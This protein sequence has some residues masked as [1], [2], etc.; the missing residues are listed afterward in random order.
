M[1]LT[2]C[3]HDKAA[4]ILASKPNK[5]DI[6]FIS[7]PENKYA[8]EGSEKIAGLARESCEILFNDITFPIGHS[9]TVP[10]E[11][12][13]KKALDF[14]KGKKEL[15]IAC[16]MGV[17]RS[18]AI[19]Y[20]IEASE[21]GYKEAFDIL[22]PKVHSPNLLVIKHGAKLL[23]EQDILAAM[24]DWKNKANALDFEW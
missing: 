8:V 4:K 12:H 13:V 22:N 19:A 15:I 20:L 9:K 24:L 14:A 3:G 1:K 17:S 10:E 2:I 21:S 11:H 23:G 6:I 18:S 5:L 7:S 16:Q